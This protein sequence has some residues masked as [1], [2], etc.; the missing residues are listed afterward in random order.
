MGQQFS[1]SSGSSLRTYHLAAR[2]TATLALLAG[3]KEEVKHMQATAVMVAAIVLSLVTSAPAVAQQIKNGT[4][5]GTLMSATAAVPMGSS[6]TVFTTPSAGP[7]IL[8][9]VCAEFGITISVSRFGPI[10]RCFFFRP[11]LALPRSATITCTN[12][13]DEDGV[14]TIIGVLSK[15]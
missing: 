3:A 15:S 8:I 14:C 7:F 9:D 10:G 2:H 13:G 4:V 12:K 11:G 5:S 1:Q 6:V